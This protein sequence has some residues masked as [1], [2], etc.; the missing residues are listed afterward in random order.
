M[1]QKQQIIIKHFVQ[2]ISHRRIAKNLGINR[3][4]V[5]RCISDYLQEK[6]A[7][8]LEQNGVIQAPQYDSSNRGKRKLTAKIQ[9]CIDEHLVNNAKKRSSGR[10]KQCMKNVD[11]HEALVEAG[12][13]IG[14]STICQYVNGYERRAQEVFIR[15]QYA[16]G[17]C[18]E[19]DWGMAKLVI[20]GKQK[21]IQLAVFTLAN[22]NHRWAMLFYRQDM[23]SFLQAHVEY[24]AAIKGV[25]AQIVYDN[26]KTAVAK[27]TIKQ[28]DKTPTDDLLKISTYYQFDYRFCNAAKG[29]EKGHVERSVEYVRRKAFCRYDQFE[30]LDAAQQQLQSTV[31]RLNEKNAKGQLQSI[32]Q[33]LNIEQEAMITLPPTAYEYAI[34]RQYRVDKYHTIC[35]DTNQYSVPESIP[36]Q[37]V[38]VRLYPH[39]IVIYDKAHQAVARHHRLHAKYQWSIDIDHYWKTMITKPGALPNS[40]ALAQ[41]PQHI[42]DLFKQY[43]QDMPK[44][45]VQLCHLCKTKSI[46]IDMLVQA[47]QLTHKQSP[48]NPL[49]VDRV[50]WNM[51][52]LIDK[53]KPNTEAVSVNPSPSMSDLIAQQCQDQLK[54][55]QA[56]F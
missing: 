56:S 54:Q 55:I 51:F 44:V 46:D 47:T 10:A 53:S 14:Y 5:K 9:E 37:I 7:L 48:H 40:Q 36:E 23:P 30:S 15:Q 17:S 25:P 42:K 27:F 20:G 1:I 43:Y 38:E 3:K 45:F 31:D 4:T 18:S 16:P 24:L 34:A 39:H 2:G 19:F 21:N 41:A 49:S 13:K 12:N 6:N 8:D 28:S 11:I 26:M 33:M 29:N 35:V 22:S 52:S 32:N 50:K